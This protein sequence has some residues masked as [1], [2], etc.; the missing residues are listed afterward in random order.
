[1][2]YMYIVY[3]FISLY[4][5]I[6][7]ISYMYTQIVSYYPNPYKHWGW[8]KLYKWICDQQT[9]CAAT[10]RFVCS[11]FWTP[12]GHWTK[13]SLLRQFY[14]ANNFSRNLRLRVWNTK[15]WRKIH[16]KPY[17]PPTPPNPRRNI[18]PKCAKNNTV[19]WVENRH[20]GFCALIPYRPY[21]S[22]SMYPYFHE[23]TSLSRQWGIHLNISW[24]MGFVYRKVKCLL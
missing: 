10:L 13:L 18:A 17:K 6:Y 9:M 5:I 12:L 7:I 22:M 14:G 1:M 19:F 20:Q 21:P 11:A 3:Q 24:M 16:L 4:I 15:V 8:E 23:R 2:L